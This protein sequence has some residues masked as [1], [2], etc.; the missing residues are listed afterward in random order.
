MA[1]TPVNRSNLPQPRRRTRMALASIPMR[2]LA[3]L[4]DDSDARALSRAP[5]EFLNEDEQQAFRAVQT[6]FAR[7]HHFP[8]RDTLMEQGVRLPE[9]PEPLDFYRDEMNN[10]IR[11]RS[12]ATLVHELQPA[13]E[14]RDGQALM[15]AMQQFRDEV[16]DP[17]LGI[18]T[19]ADA[20]ADIM[21]RFSPQGTAGVV[22]PT[23]IEAVDAALGGVRTG[24]VWAVA[25]RPGA[26][27]TFVQ[28]VAGIG[29]ILRRERV[30]WVSKELTTEEMQDRV[31][32]LS[33]GLNPGLGTNRMAS[34]LTQRIVERRIVSAL[35]S[36]DS[37]LLFLNEC[38]SPADLEVAIRECNP[39]QVLIDGTY[40][41]KPTDHN[42][43]DSRGERY[44]KLVRELQQLGKQTR[45]TIGITWQQN[46]NKA[47]GTEGL[48]GSDA[49]SQDASL[50][51]MLKK[52]K[53]NPEVRGLHV[54]KNRHG[55]EGMDIGISFQ[56]RPT[57]IGQPAD[58]PERRQQRA[59]EAGRQQHTE[60]AVRRA[61][62][63]RAPGAEEI[64]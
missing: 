7:Y 33:T 13:L 9:A 62:G 12:V 32:T 25:G 15:Q 59:V 46:R 55:P 60:Q 48:Y 10:Q 54:A 37:N 21:E 23:G 40:F 45:R 63:G 20:R 11:I 34:T 8:S 17:E 41:L 43:R 39:T 14:A 4:V 57:N 49:L 52:Y 31:L 26:G 5:V 30:L 22:R 50:V 36:R 38:K 64:G 47:F 27:K 35:Q 24:N 16:S 18:I 6:F 44:E 1:R 58:L 56:F 42:S 29:L 2:Y 28:V 3:K 53:E 19:Y 61:V 51:L